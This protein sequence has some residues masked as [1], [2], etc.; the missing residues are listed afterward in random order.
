MC[1]PC[2]L[3]SQLGSLVEDVLKV[4][5][6]SSLCVPLTVCPFLWRCL[7]SLQSFFFLRQDLCTPNWLQTPYVAEGD[8]HSLI[9][10]PA[11]SSIRVLRWPYRIY[12]MQPRA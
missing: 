6:C 2:R 12:G 10:L 7:S 8:L 1:A 4:L 3:P 9:H 11:S 5:P